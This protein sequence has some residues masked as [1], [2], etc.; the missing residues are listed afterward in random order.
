VAAF[1]F[2]WNGHWT[3]P[4]TA[5]AFLA[6]HGLVAFGIPRA[7]FA[8]LDRAASHGA[9]F[10]GHGSSTW[11]LW[12]FMERSPGEGDDAYYRRVTA[13]ASDPALFEQ[14]VLQSSKIPSSS[15]TARINATSVN[16]NANTS[17]SAPALN[18]TGY[19]RAEEWEAQEQQRKKRGEL[20]WEERVQF[21]GQ[22]YGNRV[23]QND[24]L[25]QN[26]HK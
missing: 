4:V 2:G 8:S 22:M 25:R 17:V 23:Q 19:V 11:K 12:G 15:P 3:L 24:I 1:M 5:A 16:S 14:M 21:E 26:L 9:R 7:G 18:K 6:P 20:T 13:A 10:H